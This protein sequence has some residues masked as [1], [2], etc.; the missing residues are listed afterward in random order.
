MGWRPAVERVAGESS[1]AR[2]CD[3]VRWSGG[4]PPVTG[5]LRASQGSGLAV[6]PGHGSLPHSASLEASRAG[7]ALRRAGGLKTSFG[8]PPPEDQSVWRNG[9]AAAKRSEL[10]KTSR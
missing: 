8:R 6:P 3:P 9:A 1:R 5:T 2:S 4:P 10:S 7:D